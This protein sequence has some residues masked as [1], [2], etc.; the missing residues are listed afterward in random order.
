M[1]GNSMTSG[2]GVSTFAPAALTIRPF[3][4]DDVSAV[5][6]IEVAVSPDPWSADLFAGELLGG[7]APR[8]WLVAAVDDRLVGFGGVMLT[9]DEAHIMNLAVDP[10][11]QRSGIAARLLAVLLQ[12]AGD[13]GATAATLEVRASNLAALALY[14]R[15]DFVESGGRPRYYADGEDA[16]IMWAHRI[17]RPAYRSTLER[18]AEGAADDR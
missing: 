8:C 1:S 10:S 3:T 17:H 14:R 5:H 12:T 18:V 4:I 16:V 7:G 15:F 11:T 2:D 6:R 9:V 13:R